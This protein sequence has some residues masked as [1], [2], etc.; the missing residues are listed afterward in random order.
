MVLCAC[1]AT[2]VTVVPAATAATVGSVSFT[3]GDGYDSGSTSKSVVIGVV[4]GHAFPEVTNS[5][6]PPG[7]RAR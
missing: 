7:S 3:S 4:A 1:I 6:C 2:D 5:A